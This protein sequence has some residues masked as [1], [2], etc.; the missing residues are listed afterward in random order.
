MAREKYP[1][2]ML[3]QYMVRFPEGMRDR[4]K[5]AA[6]TNKRSMNAEILAR[7]ETSFA[8]DP[9]SVDSV[10]RRVF[11]S[12]LTNEQVM[13][14]VSPEEML[15][16][17]LQRSIREAV[18][19]TLDELSSAGLITMIADIDGEKT[20]PSLYYQPNRKYR[21]KLISEIQKRRPEQDE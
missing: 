19:K 18:S 2:E 20:N 16:A 8:L 6:A 15:E 1:S 10:R 3:D 5:D 4:L 7:L 14:E 12:D 11:G 9:E 21:R 13:E 17:H